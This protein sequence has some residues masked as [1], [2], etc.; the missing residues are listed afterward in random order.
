MSQAGPLDGDFIPALRAG[1]RLRQDHARGQWVLLAPE[2]VVELDQIAVEVVQRFDGVRSLAQIAQALA[3]EFDAPA[4]D[5]QADLVELAR[6]LHA[7]H[8]LRP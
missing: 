8:L 5:I 7:K 1:V 6:N 4:A 2:R 3:A